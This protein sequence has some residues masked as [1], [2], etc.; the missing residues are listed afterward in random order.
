MRGDQ[1]KQHSRECPGQENFGKGK[2]LTDENRI[3]DFAF[4]FFV[5][6]F[7]CIIITSLQMT[8]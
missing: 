6:I 2:R 5:Y 1:E 3:I 8:K 4:S 7:I